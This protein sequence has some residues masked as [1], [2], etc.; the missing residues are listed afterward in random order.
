MRGLDRIKRDSRI[1]WMIDPDVDGPARKKFGKPRPVTKES[2]PKRRKAVR[3]LA[4]TA[5]R[6]TAGAGARNEK[7]IAGHLFDGA[8]HEE[9]DSR[10][11]VEPSD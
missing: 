7:T 11:L 3:P 2:V 8:T 10:F 4:F 6:A 1:S 9:S 5:F